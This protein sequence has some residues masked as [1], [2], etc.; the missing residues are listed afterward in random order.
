[1]RYKDELMLG[2]FICVVFLG[3][4]SFDK[5]SCL[6]KGRGFDKVEHSVTG[7]CMVHHKG[8]W[9][10]LENIRGFD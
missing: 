3:G 1:M 4:Y 10:P 9:L 6:K 7:G 5:A 8:K 2:L